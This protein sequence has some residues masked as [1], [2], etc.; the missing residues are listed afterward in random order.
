M[1]PASRAAEIYARLLSQPTQHTATLVSEGTRGRNRRTERS[2]TD[3]KR[4]E[5]DAP[6]PWIF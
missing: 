2:V 4:R 5:M 3:E 1:L 6:R